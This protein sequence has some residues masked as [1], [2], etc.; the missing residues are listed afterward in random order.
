MAKH[1]CSTVCISFSFYVWL[2]N[3]YIIMSCVCVCV[4]LCIY[5]VCMY[6]CMYVL[7]V[8]VTV[9]YTFFN[10]LHVYVGVCEDMFV[11]L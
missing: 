5:V 10:V 7:S 11:H 4:Y 6:I 8:C 1:V 9:Y 3:L 2:H